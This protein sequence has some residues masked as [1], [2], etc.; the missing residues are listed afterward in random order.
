MIKKLLHELF[1]FEVELTHS[2]AVELQSITK[3]IRDYKVRLWLQNLF[4]SHFKW[5]TNSLKDPV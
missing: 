1:M 5:P 4:N 2:V 3:L